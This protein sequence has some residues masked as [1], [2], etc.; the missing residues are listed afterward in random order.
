MVSTPRT[1]EDGKTD[2]T[3]A[4]PSG[5]P[6]FQILG[7]RVD[8]M[9]IP[10]VIEQMKEWIARREKCH[11]IAFTGLHGL[12]ESNKRPE[13]KDILNSADL[14][15]ADGMPLVWL[16]RLRG[17]ALRR[18]VY[19]PELLETFCRE[20][21]SQ[22]RHFFYGGAPGVAESL[23]RSL[24]QRFH[25]V[26]A[27][28]YSPPF[29]DLTEEEDQAVVDRVHQA[30]PDVLWVGLSTPKQESWMHEHRARLRVPVLLGVGAAFDIC[31]GN[32]R[33]APAWM[34]ENGLEWLF[35][36]SVEPRRLWRRYLVTI[37]SV[38]WR[39]SFEIVGPKKLE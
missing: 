18:R 30:A 5:Q 33:Q 8:A 6:C 19:G 17:H 25:I 37:P 14:V 9:Q 27:G 21:Q 4:A 28:A 15:V 11:S 26:V 10:G 34:R 32:L 2:R 31:S 16:G 29:R 39:I 36:L 3:L 7:L 22:F 1:W 13:F 38:L 35:R 12:S 24:E 20:T 23:A